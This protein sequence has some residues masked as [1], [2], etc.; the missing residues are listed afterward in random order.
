[1]SGKPK[2][3]WHADGEGKCHKECEQYKADGCCSIK[4]MLYPDIG[5]VARGNCLFA[6]LSDVLCVHRQKPDQ[7][8]IEANRQFIEILMHGAWGCGYNYGRERLPNENGEDVDRMEVDVRGLMKSEEEEIRRVMVDG[9]L[10]RN[11]R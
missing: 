7:S 4:T 11:E 6:V 9:V 10:R 8:Q 1:M 5:T 2:L 3:M